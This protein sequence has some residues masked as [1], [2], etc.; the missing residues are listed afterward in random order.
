M[1]DT[2]PN[3]PT[4][5][6]SQSL[7]AD[8]RASGDDCAIPG[9]SIDSYEAFLRELPELMAS[10]PGQCAAY[11]DG[12]RVGIGP[13]R[14]EFFKQMYDTGHDPL[15]LLFFTIEPQIPR[16]IELLTPDLANA[17]DH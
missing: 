6:A 5:R 17:D 11:V 9:H 12:K 15:R 7:P 16:E 14:R 2:D 3:G 13:R 1:I 10:S 8:V 4:R